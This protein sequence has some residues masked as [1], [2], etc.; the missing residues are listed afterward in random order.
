MDSGINFK[1]ASLSNVAVI[2]NILEQAPTYSLKTEGVLP[3]AN[4]GAETLSALPPQRNAEQKYVLIVEVGGIPSGVIDF[5]DGY[6]DE[7]CGFIGL[8]L[9]SESIQGNGIGRLVYSELEKW[10]RANF[11]YQRLRL[12]V[13]ES[14]PVTSFWE[15]MG[16]RLTGETRPHE[17]VSVR[18]RK[19]LMEKTLKATLQ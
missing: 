7:S 17:G 16:F 13:V 3:S 10:I 6:P 14:N 8:F 4:A 18:S 9:L 12:G 5:I 11:S 19:L 2:Q 15:K 1:H